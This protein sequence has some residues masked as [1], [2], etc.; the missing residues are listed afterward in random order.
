MKS[1]QLKRSGRENLHLIESSK[2]QPE[3]GQILVRTKAVSLRF[4]ECM[5]DAD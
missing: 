5:F 3:A 4:A 1:W 2:P